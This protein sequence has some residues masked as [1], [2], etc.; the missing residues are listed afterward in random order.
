MPW[1]RIAKV[2]AAFGLGLT[3]LFAEALRRERREKQESEH[4]RWT[5]KNRWE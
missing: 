1:A 3:A 5:D 2:T 4:V